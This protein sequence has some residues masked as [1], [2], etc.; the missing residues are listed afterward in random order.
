MGIAGHANPAKLVCGI[1]AQTDEVGDAAEAMLDARFGPTDLRSPRRPFT[2]SSYYAPEMGPDLIRWWV[3]FERL[4][5][6]ADISS[7]KVATNAMERD[8]TAAD[9]RRRVNLDPGYIVP[10]RLVLVTTKDFAHRI[11]L[12]D[13]I[14]G[15]V[16]LLWQDGG[17]V[18]MEWTY[19]DYRSDDAHTF[20]VA[21]RKRL[22]AQLR[23]A[24]AGNPSRG[25]TD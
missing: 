1:L 25:E 4:V 2:E 18:P 8:F 24:Q 21:V 11:Y 14:Y 9:G 20:F 3:A 23:A 6:E 16:T 5:T 17:F 10:S 15:E 7:A 13:G 19:P 12:A 22:M